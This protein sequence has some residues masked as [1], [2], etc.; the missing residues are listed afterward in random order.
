MMVSKD[1]LREK[2]YLRLA[3][4]ADE[5]S[6]QLL[7]VYILEILGDGNNALYKLLA[8]SSRERSGR[9]FVHG[10]FSWSSLNKN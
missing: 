5:L 8:F 4:I 10:P 9:G 1:D 2:L 6:V 7:A 3:A